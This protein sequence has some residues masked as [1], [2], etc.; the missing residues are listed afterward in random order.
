MGLKNLIKGQLL[1]SI[2]YRSS[3]PQELAA[4][5]DRDGRRIMYESV[6]TV[7]PGQAAI[8]VN[9]RTDDGYFYAGPI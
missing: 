8:L 5:Y 7:M 2:S 3:D 1:S 6:L 9:R 4:V